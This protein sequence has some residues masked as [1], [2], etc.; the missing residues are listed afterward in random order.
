MKTTSC[1]SVIWENN[2]ALKLLLF[3]IE[4]PKKEFY[5]SEVSLETEISI[6]AT[7]KYLKM[8]LEEGYLTRE[9]KGKMNFYRLNR[10]EIVRFLTIAYNLSKPF[11]SEIRDIGRRFNAKIYLYGSFSRGENDEYSD[12]DILVL[13]KVNMD[14]NREI[15]NIRKKYNINLKPN[16]FTRMDWLMMREKDPAFYERVE[17]D[18][19]EL[20]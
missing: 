8:L 15:M 14:F 12:I 13:G 3:F 11:I 6:G 18:R 1:E 7:N 10:T 5:E 4:H 17:K 20:I 19:I 16:V 2:T 9:K